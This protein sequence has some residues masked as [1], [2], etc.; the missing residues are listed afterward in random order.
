MNQ[1]TFKLG[2][3][4]GIGSGKS[5]VA[6]FLRDAGAKVIDADA[7]S[8][9]S[10]GPDGFAMNQI[11]QTFGPIYVSADGSL[12]RQKMREHVFQNAQ[13]RK[14]LEAI[15]HPL[16]KQEIERLTQQAIASGTQLLVYDVPLLVESN[17]WRAQ[18]NR[19][20]V[21]DCSESTQVARVKQRSQLAAEEVEAII[22][23]QSSRQARLAA[24][25]WVIFNDGLDLAELK[26]EVENLPISQFF[27]TN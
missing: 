8:R 3:T 11:A 6:T 21:I 2:L 23:V 17:H 26:H 27:N 18:V 20:L 4:G 5:T 16:V 10:T 24:A 9:S 12:N 22:K 25:D 1:F 14:Q 13:A 7:V 15:I 19:V